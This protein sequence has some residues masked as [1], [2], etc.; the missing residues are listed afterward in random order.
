MQAPDVNIDNATIFLAEN[1]TSSLRFN[2]DLLTG[3]TISAVIYCVVWPIIILSGI[4]GNM[5]TLRVIGNIGESSATAM[6]LKSLA[7]SDTATLIFRASQLVFIWGQ[8]FWPHWYL[9][10]KVGSNPF[11]KCSQMSE[12]I[13][14]CLTIAIASERVVAV[15]R[16][17]RYRMVCTP[18]RAVVVIL[19]IMVVCISL[20]LPT[21]VDLSI[22]QLNAQNNRT[23]SGNI[24]GRVRGYQRYRSTGKS[25]L[26]FINL[27]VFD[28]MPIP[29]AMVCNVVIIVCL[30]KGM[31]ATK[32]TCEAQQRKCRKEKNLTRLLLTVSML[33]LVLCGPFEIRRILSKSKSIGSNEFGVLGDILSTLVLANSSINFLI[34]SVMNKKYR[35]GFIAVLGCFRRSNSSQDCRGIE[36]IDMS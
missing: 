15:T 13:S 24:G 34:Y 21:I 33:F 3:S 31:N 5:L 35:E 6:F 1:L 26:D 10:W 17:I 18:M 19:I 14:K 28:F 32:V 20:S 29:I 25:I 23:I 4:C 16:P 11:Y 27:I 36:V 7:I 30:R 9:T 22:Y 8:I 12:R 2:S